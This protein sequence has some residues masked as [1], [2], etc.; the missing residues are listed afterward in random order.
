METDFSAAAD[1]QVVS[2]WLFLVFDN[3][4]VQR[5]HTDKPVLVVASVSE[6]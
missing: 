6:C 5:Y 4:R 2:V 3:A 1:R